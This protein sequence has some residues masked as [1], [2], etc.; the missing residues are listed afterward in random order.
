MFYEKYISFNQSLIW[1]KK[2]LDKTQ[3]QDKKPLAEN[4]TSYNFIADYFNS[5]NQKEI[6]K[7]IN[8]NRSK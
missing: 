1:T 8:K 4:E 6:M 5:P 7:T 2:Y 3:G